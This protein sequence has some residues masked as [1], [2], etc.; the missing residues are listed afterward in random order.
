MK[1][2]NGSGRSPAKL[3]LEHVR[4]RGILGSKMP[5]TDLNSV[6]VPGAAA[7]WA[8]TVE[9]FGSGKLSLLEVLAPAIRLAEEG[10]ASLA[11]CLNKGSYHLLT[12]LQS[13][14]STV[15][16]L[17]LTLY[18]GPSKSD[19][20]EQ[21][22]RS[23][24]AIKSASPSGDEM[25]VNGKAPHPGQIFKS[26]TLAATFRALGEQGKDGFYKGRVAEA[27]VELIQSKGGKMELSDL[28][29]HETDFVEPIKM[30]YG[31]EVTVY[32]VRTTFAR[33]G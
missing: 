5:R 8:D 21:W 6:T 30:S 2:L 18:I 1:A 3:T 7:A 9:R 22:M 17:V 28:A 14:R 23:E 26:P 24:E 20:E 11:V 12:V 10:Y 15:S 33:H 25:L 29:S 32:E 19:H 31:D 13:L 16:V 4:S 27:I